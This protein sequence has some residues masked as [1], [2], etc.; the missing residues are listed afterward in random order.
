MSVIVANTNAGARRLYERYGYEAATLPCV[1]DGWESDTE[2]WV[3]LIKSLHPV[4][5]R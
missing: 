1:K 2:H 4:E 3:L 5:G